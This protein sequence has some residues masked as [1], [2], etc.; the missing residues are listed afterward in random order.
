MQ[1]QDRPLIVEPPP[2]PR[3]RWL[4]P[5]L[6]G[7]A[8][9][10][11]AIVMVAAL[12]SGGSDDEPDSGTTPQTTVTTPPTTLPAVIPTVA[13]EGVLTTSLMAGQSALPFFDTKTDPVSGF[14]I[15]LLNEAADRAGL[16]MKPLLR[17]G[18]NEDH[19]ESVSTGQIQDVHAGSLTISADREQLV[20][21]TIPY[22]LSQLALVVNSA[23][24]PEITAVADLV[25]GDRVTGG[26]PW[27][28]ENLAPVGIEPVVT[29]FGGKT[30]FQALSDG[31]V[32]AVVADEVPAGE[33]IK[34]FPNLSIVEVIAVDESFGFAV[35]P[36][37]QAL[38][39]ALN[40]A[41]QSMI[42]DGTYQ[43][44]YDQWFDTPGGSVAP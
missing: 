18:F 11:V 38:L 37:N 1:T 7:A 24:T 10:I 36:N 43:T 30:P 14:E 5:A 19:L 39:D 15:D 22:Y 16:T 41:L 2:P 42:D 8:G 28:E 34:A 35:D 13:G 44:I 32:E 31:D 29:V 27:I 9:V 6:A 17:A 21:F 25:E 26:N 3:K 12:A 33:T 40:G 23:L 20:S 4:V